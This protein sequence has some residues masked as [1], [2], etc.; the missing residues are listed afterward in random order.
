[1]KIDDNEELLN[2]GSRDH[3]NDSH[4][5]RHQVQYQM[6]ESEASDASFLELTT[7]IGN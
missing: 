4:S 2:E 6:D 3:L 1:M 7:K 5:I